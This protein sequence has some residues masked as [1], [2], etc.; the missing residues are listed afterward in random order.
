MSGA[1][2]LFRAGL[3][4][5]VIGTAHFGTLPVYPGTLFIA[6]PN[7]ATV[8]Y[9]LTFYNDDGSVAAQTGNLILPAFQR[10]RYEV[11]SLKDANGIALGLNNYYSLRVNATGGTLGGLTIIRTLAGNFVGNHM[12]QIV[13]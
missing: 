2:T 6:N 11:S 4:G 10:A 5:S 3:A 1:F 13:P 12:A 8:T 7:N 9:S